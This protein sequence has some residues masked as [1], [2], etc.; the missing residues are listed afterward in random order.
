M[1]TEPLN[2]VATAV[3]TTCA[4][5][6]VAIVATVTNDPVVVA[7]AVSTAIVLVLAGAG[8]MVVQIINARS[9]AKGLREAA[10][11][12]LLHLTISKETS[13]AVKD[14]AKKAAIIVTETGKIH[15]LADGTNSNLRKNLEVMAEKMAG[16][17]KV[18][19]ELHT[20]K[21]DAATV[22]ALA[23]QKTNLTTV[24]PS[25]IPP[26]APVAEVVIVNSAKNPANVIDHSKPKP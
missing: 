2:F 8:T 21:A 5:A 16:M 6:G 22:R 20:A 19:A 7:G 14:T 11:E 3:A 10:A 18:I 26:I 9:V 23:D 1:N 24:L 15:E 12:R 25:A 13:E 17:E 4:T